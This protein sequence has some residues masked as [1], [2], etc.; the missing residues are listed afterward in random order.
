MVR[1]CTHANRG[2]QP[3]KVNSR[4]EY[5]D[6]KRMNGLGTICNKIELK[7][8]F[9]EQGTRSERESIGKETHWS[10]HRKI[11]DRRGEQRP[12]GSTYIEE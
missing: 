5:T 2:R 10:G 9:G 12:V 8:L 6:L 7:E 3:K 1:P 4:E 11:I